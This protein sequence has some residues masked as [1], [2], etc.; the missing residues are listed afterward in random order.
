MQKRKVKPTRRRNLSLSVFG[1][2]FFVWCHVLQVG[3][4]SFVGGPVRVR[5]RI[6]WNRCS[7]GALNFDNDREGWV[8]SPGRHVSPWQG[9]L[10]R[11][12]LGGFTHTLPARTCSQPL[13]YYIGQ[14]PPHETLHRTV[15][16][17]R[18]HGSKSLFKVMFTFF[19][20]YK[21]YDPL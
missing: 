18:R 7:N 5:R 14:N 4:H 9:L 1:R 3:Y 17:K 6:P 10:W 2:N 8:Q 13:L 12:A 19:V 20:L 15:Q 16:G 21:Y 11:G